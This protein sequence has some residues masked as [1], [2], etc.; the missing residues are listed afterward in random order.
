[1][2]N[3]FKTKPFSIR[4]SES[5]I[6][7]L[8]KS[9]IEMEKILGSN[10]SQDQLILFLSKTFLGLLNFEEAQKLKIEDFNIDFN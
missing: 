8:Q 2:S 1:M 7:I 4:L 10:V 6:Q 9:K 5:T 3:Y